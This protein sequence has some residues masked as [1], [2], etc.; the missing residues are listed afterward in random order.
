MHNDPHSSVRPTPAFER[1]QAEFAAYIRDPYNNPPPSDVQPARMVLYRELFFNNID[2]FLA[3]SF[4]VLRAILNDGQWQEL[5]QDF[6]SRHRCATPHF[7]EIA[8]EFLVFLQTERQNPGDYPFLT[9]LAHYEWVEL[10]LSIATETVLQIADADFIDQLSERRIALSPV[11]WSLVYRYPVE[12]LAPDYLPVTPPPLP[13]YLLVYRGYD[14]EVHFIKT[15]ALTYAMLQWL[16]EQGPQRVTDLLNA[17]ITQLPALS[18]EQI[19]EGAIQ[20][21]RELAVKGIVVPAGED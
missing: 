9:E 11:A 12:K 15:T 16:D 19:L 5:T 20:T 4:P 7:S 18:R 17:L 3:S 14:D 10:A 21:L 13:T 2:G 1:K 6:Y 8:E